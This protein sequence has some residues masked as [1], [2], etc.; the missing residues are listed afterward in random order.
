LARLAGP[1]V[2]FLGSVDDA[3]KRCYLD[4]CRAFVFPEEADFGIAPLEATA[5]GRPVVAY[6]GG[7]ALDTVID[8]ET[9]VLVET[10]QPESL[11][12]ALQRVESICW[13]RH[14][15]AA[16]AAT[17]SVPAF[18]SRL[19]SF[20]DRGVARHRQEAFTGVARVRPGL[21]SA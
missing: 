6:A 2:E 1:T 11:A 4:G 20:V 18:E 5:A 3:T 8:G 12:Y 17:F 7:G 21:R 10:Q 13:D 15:I 16:H 14:A 19:K 9:G